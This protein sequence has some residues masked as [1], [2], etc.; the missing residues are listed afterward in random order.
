M[1]PYSGRVTDKFGNVISGASVSVLDSAGTLAALFDVAGAVIGNPL[2]S[3]ERGLITFYAANGRYTLRTAGAGISAPELAV[4]LSDPDYSMRVSDFLADCILSGGLIPDSADLSATT[5]A[6]VG[7]VA[8]RRIATPATARTYTASR[9]TYV[10]VN[11]RGVFTYVEAA[12]GALEPAVTA[13]AMRIA[14]VVTDATQIVSVTDRRPLHQAIKRVVFGSLAVDFGAIAA[15]A[16][17]D[18]AFTLFGAQAGR[19]LSFGCSVAPPAGIVL[20]AFC[21]AADTVTV[22]AANVTAG[23]IDPGAV[24]IEVEASRYA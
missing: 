8:G 3:D 5:P 20:M 6:M 10:D 19:P 21:A 22:R 17:A 13:G 24:T 23:A 2:T 12:L 18:L 9:D 16:T 1:Q 14:K 4:Q 11:S 7:Y 15:Q